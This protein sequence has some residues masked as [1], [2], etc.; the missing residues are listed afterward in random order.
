MIIRTPVIPGVNEDVG[1]IAAI[2]SFAA[3][4]RNV[5]QYELLPYHPLGNSKRIAL[6]LKEAEFE[7]P[8]RKKMEELNQY[9]FL[10]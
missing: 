1:T 3:D 9:A 6:G 8:S 7:V 2:S 5:Y 10:R 4:L